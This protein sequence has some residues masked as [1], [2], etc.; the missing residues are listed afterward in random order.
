MSLWWP[1]DLQTIISTDNEL[2]SQAAYRAP[3]YQNANDQWK[4]AGEFIRGDLTHILRKTPGTFLGG[5]K[6]PG[7]ADSE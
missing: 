4:S 1:S 2:T 6:R 3:F 5:A 7:A